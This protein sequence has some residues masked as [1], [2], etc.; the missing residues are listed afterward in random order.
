MSSTPLAQRRQINRKHEDAV[1]EIFAKSSLPDL[2]FE[3]AM[4]RDDHSHV[5]GKRLI[6]ADA[7]D[8]TFFQHPQQFRLHGGRHVSDFVEEQSAAVGLLEFSGV[9]R[10]RAGERAFF[11][12]E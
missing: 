7:L 5:H 10:G 12:A 1:V 3:V 6:S 4:G 9:A 8:F 11:V 2:V